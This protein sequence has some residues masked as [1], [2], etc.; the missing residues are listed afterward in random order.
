MSIDDFM[1]AIIIG[2]IGLTGAYLIAEFMSWRR[3]VAAERRKRAVQR[4]LH[5]PT[6]NAAAENRHRQWRPPSR[7][8]TSSRCS[9][10][11]NFPGVILSALVVAVI[12]TR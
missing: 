6:A 5:I 7:T 4:E 9:A 12:L 11:A 8:A 3:G 2:G 1:I 10:I